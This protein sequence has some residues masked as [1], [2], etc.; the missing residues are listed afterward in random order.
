MRSLT[1][2]LT[3]TGLIIVL[4]FT[5][6]RESLSKSNETGNEKQ[7]QPSSSSVSIKKSD[8]FREEALRSAALS[9][10]LNEVEKL[11]LQNTDFKAIDPDGRTAVMLAA[12]NGFTNI[13]DL[14][15]KKGASINQTDFEGRTALM[16]AAT[17]PNLAT[18]ELLL[19]RKAEINMADHTE[20]FTALMYAAAEGQLEIVKKLLESGADPF[21]KDK[22]NEDA[23]N[24]ARKNGHTVISE[25]LKSY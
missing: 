9:G 24:F 12:F 23:E 11:L 20:K 14:L 7:L 8:T 21:L 3:L 13:V 19:S 16:Y 17:G 2:V 22:D 10:D 18:V 1:I 25:L 5:S 15:L 6:C 4:F